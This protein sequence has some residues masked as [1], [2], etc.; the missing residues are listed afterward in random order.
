MSGCVG[1]SQEEKSPATSGRI[2]F[3]DPQGVA[4]EILVIEEL[5]KAIVRL[6]PWG[7]SSGMNN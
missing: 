4:A 6:L 7:K 2:D 5:R 3:E 1:E